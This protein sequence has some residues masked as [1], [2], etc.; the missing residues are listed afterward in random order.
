MVINVVI[1]YMYYSFPSLMAYTIHKLCVL[2]NKYSA[3]L[4]LL[5]SP[6]DPVL[7]GSGPSKLKLLHKQANDHTL[8]YFFIIE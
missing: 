2:I 3:R 6:P 1:I 5:V 8:G 7:V 4:K